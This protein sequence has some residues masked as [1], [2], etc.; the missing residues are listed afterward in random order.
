MI[1]NPK[2]AAEIAREQGVL[3]QALFA[4]FREQWQQAITD[5]AL[6]P[7][8]QERHA[9]STVLAWLGW[10]DR[11]HIGVDT[12]GVPDF[13][14]VEIPVGEF[15]YQDGQLLNLPAFR[16]S[17]YSVTHMQFQAFVDAG[18]YDTE[19]WWDGLVKPDSPPAPRFQEGNR[20]ID[21]VNWYEA[22]AFCRWL[23][24]RTG[25]SI[26]LPTEQEWEKAARGT[27]GRQYPWGKTFGHEYLNSQWKL[28]GTSAVGIY[29]NGQSRYGLMDMSGNVWEWCL[30][31]WT[32]IPPV[33]IAAPIAEVSAKQVVRGGSWRLGGDKS[34]TT[35]RFGNEPYVRYYI[36]G[37]RPVLD[38]PS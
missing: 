12:S 1:G 28:G 32:D 18:G 15:I 20:P 21:S 22:L 2:L 13:D 23:S 11:P 30:D 35:L 9:I 3:D 26:R 8:P 7:D 38:I 4:A 29:P 14:W 36:I 10:D 19:Q 33:E 31:A 27:D 37:F 17:R 25:Q 16:M 6:R 34:R 5:I 24:A